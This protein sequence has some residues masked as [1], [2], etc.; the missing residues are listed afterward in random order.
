MRN[1]SESLEHF[2]ELIEIPRFRKNL[3]HI[4]FF[5]LQKEY[6]ELMPDFNWFIEDMKFFFEFLDELDEFALRNQ[7]EQLDAKTTEDKVVDEGIEE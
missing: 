7:V 2:L 3:R 6:E 1:S 5:Y 4:L